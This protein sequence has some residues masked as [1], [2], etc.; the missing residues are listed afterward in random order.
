[1]RGSRKA[2]EE[3]SIPVRTRKEMKS[4]LERENY[5]TSR[6]PAAAAAVAA[7]SSTIPHRLECA[8]E[9]NKCV[10][11]TAKLKRNIITP[12]D[13]ALYIGRQEAEQPN[14]WNDLH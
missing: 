5:K 2:N 1:M 4:E 14:I 3:N 7:D 11:G 9:T 12:R 10:L 13:C 6:L 8:D